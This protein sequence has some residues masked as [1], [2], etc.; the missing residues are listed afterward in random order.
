M[1]RTIFSEEHKMFR[2]SF[3]SFVEREIVPFHE[4]WE[5][6]GVVP[7]ELWGKAGSHGFLC[8]WLEERYGGVGADFLYGMIVTEELAR[9]GASGVGFSLHSDII[10]PYIYHY[11]SEEQK[12][13]WLPGC[14]SGDTILAIAMTEPGAGSDLAAIRTTAIR[15]GDNYV[16]NGQ[17]TFISN[18]LL[19]DLL[20]VAAK[21]DPKADPPY[22]G[23]SLIVVEAGTPGFNKSRKLMKIGMKAQDT[24]ELSFEDCVVPASNLLGEEGQGFYFL[25]QQLAQERLMIAFG[26]LAG[27]E[28]ILEMTIQYCRE[29]TAFGRPISRFQNTRFKLAELAT[30]IE[31]GRVFLDRMATEHAA[32]KNMPKEASMAKWWVTELLKRTADECLQFFGGY[33]YMLEYPI[34]KAF[35]DARVSTIYAGTT[36]IM[37]E[38]IA[39]QMGL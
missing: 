21:T 25:M 15:D 16:L 8:P 23:V 14:A 4:K 10:A 9:V 35:L 24:A 5:E 36:E 26:A 37:K 17:K 7:R 11:G 22:R 3:R 13:R 31:I 19:C 2:D 27:A 12:K 1:E 28:A 30:E 20:I 34:A 29:R 6:D 18:G 32:G 39:R 38:I 33:G